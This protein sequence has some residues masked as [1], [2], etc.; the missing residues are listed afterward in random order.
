MKYKFL[1][2][3]NYP[4]YKI[5]LKTIDVVRKV[6]LKDYNNNYEIIGTFTIKPPSYLIGYYSKYNK[7][8]VIKYLNKYFVD[9]NDH[10]YIYGTGTTN[11]FNFETTPTKSYMNKLHYATIVPGVT[12]IGSHVFHLFKITSLDIPDTVTKLSTN[13]IYGCESMTSF[14][15]P[16]SINVLN[17]IIC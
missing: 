9:N 11:N 10:I 6:K 3:W 14:T 13:S 15:F 7:Q 1:Q 4:F 2:L 16:P 5:D 12:S 8:S 17:D